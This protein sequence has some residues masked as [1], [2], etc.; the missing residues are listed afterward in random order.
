MATMVYQ[1][2]QLKAFTD[3][4]ICHYILAIT[5]DKQYTGLWLSR[6]SEKSTAILVFIAEPFGVVLVLSLTVQYSI[7]S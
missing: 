5:F 1:H 6:P 4:V 7:S 2:M 3:K